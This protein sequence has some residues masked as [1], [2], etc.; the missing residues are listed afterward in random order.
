[1][2]PLYLKGVEPLKVS[3]DGPALKVSQPGAADRRF[4]L[5]RVS[6]VIVSNRVTWS[7][8]A[9]L[10]CADEG[11]TVCFLSR[12]GTP[13]ARWTG[14]P[15]PRSE[16]LQR[17]HDFVDRPDWRELFA[18]WRTAARRRA[19]R[20]CALRMGWSPRQPTRALVR[21][22]LAPIRESAGHDRYR[23]MRRQIHG[24]ARTRALADLSNLGLGAD[25]DALAAV[26]PTLA[27]SI[28]WGLHPELVRWLGASSRRDGR[29]LPMSADLSCDSKDAIHF[30]ER[31]ADSCAFHLRDSLLH[32][33][34]YME[35]HQ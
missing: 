21:T 2:K 25:D 7:T 8:R 34:R 13:R 4:P 30:F 35:S 17:W 3:L 31:H 22:V 1:M 9:L 33:K 27:T 12:D 20:F 18:Q 24:L 11:I 14:R 15:S 5:R 26:T 28:Q 10:A 23:E 16:F 19:V 32:L 6:R 29:Q